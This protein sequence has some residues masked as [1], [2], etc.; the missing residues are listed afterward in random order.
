M[1]GGLVHWTSSDDHPTQPTSF[2]CSL[3]SKLIVHCFQYYLVYLPSLGSAF[4]ISRLLPI[5]VTEAV[6]FVRLHNGTQVVLL[7][8]DKG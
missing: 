1:L 2:N 7:L 6:A 5:Q 3:C 8:S 4:E